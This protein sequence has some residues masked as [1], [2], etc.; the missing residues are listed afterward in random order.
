MKTIDDSKF[1]EVNKKLEEQLCIERKRWNSDLQELIQCL[2][3]NH[4]LANA[5]VTQLSYRQMMVESLTQYR[6]LL[7]KKQEDFDKQKISRFRD[8]S[9]SYDLKLTNPEKNQ[10]SESDLSGIKF[11]V[12]ILQTQIEYFSES[13]KLL[14]NFGFAVKNRLQIISEQLV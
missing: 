11:Q 14:D 8:Y 3:N 6:I 12:K 4:D 5:Q 9:V 1:I 13:I 2:K 10:F 7:E